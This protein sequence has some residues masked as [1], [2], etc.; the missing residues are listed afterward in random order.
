[1][2]LDRAKPSYVGGIL[3]M[4]NARLYPFWGALTE[5]LHTG[6]PQ[7]EAKRAGN[8]FDALYAD[9]ATAAQF[10]ASMTGLSLAPRTRS[11]RSFRGKSIRR[12]WILERH[13]A[14]WRCNWLWRMGI[15][16]RRV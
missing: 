6:K 16:W 14:G 7:N 9:P 11:R 10:L 12:L 8:P 1:M 15:C 2:F 5:A 13:R 4:A 3:E